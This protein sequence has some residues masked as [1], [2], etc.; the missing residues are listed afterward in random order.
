MLYLQK[1]GSYQHKLPTKTTKPNNKEPEVQV[2]NPSKSVKHKANLNQI[3]VDNEDNTINI[4]KE[5]N[6]TEKVNQLMKVR[7]ELGCACKN[8]LSKKHINKN[9]WYHECKNKKQISSKIS[10][11]IERKSQNELLTTQIN[12]LKNTKEKET[13]RQ[14]IRKLKLQKLKNRHQ[15]NKFKLKECELNDIDFNWDDFTAQHD[16]IELKL[17]SK[18]THKLYKTNTGCWKSCYIVNV[19]HMHVP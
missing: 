8:K 4:D 7:A 15:F 11:K 16:K 5:I 13:K 18:K 9:K 6:V 2:C 17:P 14:Y 10:T 19:Q 1:N 12:K 3:E